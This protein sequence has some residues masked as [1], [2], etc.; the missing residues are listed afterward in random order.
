M[1]FPEI[2]G[3]IRQGKILPLY[4]FWGPEKW[5]IDEILGEIERKTLVPATRDFNREVLDAEEVAAEHILASFQVFPVRSPWRLVIVRQADGTWKKNPD[6]FIDYFQNPNPRTCAVFLGERAD[7]RVRFFQ[8]LEKNG[9]VLSFYPP[10]EKYFPQWV[11]NQCEQMGHP[12]SGPAIALLLERIGPSLQDIH[13]ELQKIIL[14]KE[15]GSRIEEEDVLALTGDA[16]NENPFDFPR[17]LRRLDPKESLR[18]LRKN[19]QQGESPVFLFSQV[20][21]QLRLIQR[22]K[23]LRAEGLSKREVEGKLRIFPRLAGDF[24]SQVEKFAPGELHQLW[25]L[26][27]KTDQSLKLSRSDKGILLEEY[28]LRFI[29]PPGGPPENSRRETQ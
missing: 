4:Y 28:I 8:S 23:E 11:R 21:R 9:I 17:A 14:A 29:L 15:R 12:I 6:P 27:L 10:P 3:E 1:K 5:W 16:R 26:T 13:G 19:L 7:L 2:L 22:A 20:V 24:W 18:L 25:P